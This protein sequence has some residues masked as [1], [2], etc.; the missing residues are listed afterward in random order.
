MRVA[1]IVGFPRG[2]DK[3]RVQ[4]ASTSFR[5]MKLALSQGDMRGLSEVVVQREPCNT[6]FTAVKLHWYG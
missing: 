6:L 1:P 5:A 4:S 3:Q 2:F